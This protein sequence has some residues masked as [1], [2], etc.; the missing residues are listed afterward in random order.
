[1]DA[2]KFL[3]AISVIHENPGQYRVQGMKYLRAADVAKRWEN[4]I[5]TGTLANWRVQGK[6]PPYVKLG[7]KVLYPIDKLEAW[8]AASIGVANDNSPQAKS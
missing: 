8:E 5:S 3:N 4:A 2:Q 7:S 6:G 1:V